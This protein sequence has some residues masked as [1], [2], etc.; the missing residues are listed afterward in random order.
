MGLAF[1]RR[2]KEAMHN[3]ATNDTHKFNCSINISSQLCYTR[4]LE[5]ARPERGISS[6]ISSGLVTIEG[7]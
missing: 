4:A 7:K 2:H 5:K 3:T 1:N 6:C